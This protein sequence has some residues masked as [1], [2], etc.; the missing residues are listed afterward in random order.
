MAISAL[1]CTHWDISHDKNGFILSFTTL[2]DEECL[3]KNDIN[4]SIK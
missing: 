3:T 4:C 1:C 2:F